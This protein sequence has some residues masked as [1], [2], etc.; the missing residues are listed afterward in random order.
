MAR[1]RALG[2]CL[3]RVLPW[4]AH[5]VP[6]ETA[7]SLHRLPLAVVAAQRRGAGDGGGSAAGAAS[8]LGGVAGTG[9]MPSIWMG[10]LSRYLL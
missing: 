10:Q 6:P 1:L 5:L 9:S 7:G 2:A 4:M 8:V 3:L